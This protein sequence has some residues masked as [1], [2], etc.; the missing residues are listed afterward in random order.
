MFSSRNTRTRNTFF[1]LRL[2]LHPRRRFFQRRAG[3]KQSRLEVEP[4]QSREIL[5]DR[6]KIVTIGKVFKQRLDLNARSSENWSPAKE[7]FAPDDYWV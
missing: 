1:R 2:P 5:D 7:P 6:I 3:L 4:I